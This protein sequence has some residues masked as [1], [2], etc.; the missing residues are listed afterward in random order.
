MKILLFLSLLSTGFSGA[1]TDFEIFPETNH[2]LDSTHKEGLIFYEANVITLDPS[3]YSR[4]PIGGL[5]LKEK[6]FTVKFN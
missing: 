3:G 6:D 1:A 5:L 4:D 2:A